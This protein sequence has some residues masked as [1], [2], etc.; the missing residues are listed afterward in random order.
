MFSLIYLS[1]QNISFS[2]VHI[3][4][5][6]YFPH[7][8]LSLIF[9]FSSLKNNQ[10]CLQF[11]LSLSGLIYMKNWLL[12]PALVVAFPPSTSC[13]CLSLVV[14]FPSQSRHRSLYHPSPPALDQ[15]L[16]FYLKPYK[17]YTVTACF[18]SM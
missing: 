16:C 3:L 6:M 17:N 10:G 18:I 12:A 1:L 14:L 4:R 2:P 8:L 5:K 9:F 7:N 13:H 11:V 15:I